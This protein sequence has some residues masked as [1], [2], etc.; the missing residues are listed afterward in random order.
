MLDATVYAK[1]K[2]LSES[3]HACGWSVARCEKFSEEVLGRAMSIDHGAERDRRAVAA[4][5]LLP[6]IGPD[7]TS[8]RL[9]VCRR[10]VYNLAKAA[11]EDSARNMDVAC[12][13]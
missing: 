8:E 6:A 1:L 7:A 2:E 13:K 9:G 4:A 5:K 10:S 12:T 3:L 11:N